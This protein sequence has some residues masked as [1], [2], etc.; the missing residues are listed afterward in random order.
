[1]RNW[2]RLNISVMELS[3]NELYKLLIQEWKRNPPR[4]QHLNRIYCRY[5]RLRR[6]REREGL[7]LPMREG[8]QRPQKTRR[9]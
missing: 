4:I 6:D 3:E 1:M 2:E 9:G 7:G 8:V 5:S